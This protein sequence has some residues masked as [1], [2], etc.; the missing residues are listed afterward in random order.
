[1]TAAAVNRAIA[2]LRTLK[3]EALGEEAW[4]YAVRLLPEAG[5]RNTPTDL[6]AVSIM[7]IVLYAA[8]TH[9]S[10]DSG[11]STICRILEAGQTYL[12]TGC[13]S[14]DIFRPSQMYPERLENQMRALTQL[15]PLTVT[16]GIEAVRAAIFPLLQQS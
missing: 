12:T 15:P 3:P 2:R 7:A 13:S 5:K 8:A 10:E 4:E 14:A 16:S 1:M 9:V 11:V 6:A